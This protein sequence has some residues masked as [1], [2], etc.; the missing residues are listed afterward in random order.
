M[1]LSENRICRQLIIATIRMLSY[2][3]MYAMQIMRIYRED[4]ETLT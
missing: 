1:L 2:M 3:E 4:M